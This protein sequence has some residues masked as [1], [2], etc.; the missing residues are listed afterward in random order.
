MHS[1]YSTEPTV[2]SSPV[3]S[4]PAA[5]WSALRRAPLRFAAVAFVA[6]CAA[7]V[8]SSCSSTSDPSSGG[9]TTAINLVAYSTPASAYAKLISAFEQTS[10]GKNISVTSSFGASGTQAKDV[11]NG[12][13]A[14]VVNFSLEPDMA[15]LVKAGLVSA[16]WDTVGPAHGMV[17]NSV[18]V[19]VVRKGNPDHIQNW[20]DLIRSG[21]K[22][23]TPNPFSSGSAR[24]N[25]MA[26]YGAAL[27]SGDSLPP[28]RVT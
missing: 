13:P 16:D 5:R 10:A 28:P 9:G 18:V 22:V 1:N 14:D 21:V 11:V 3:H 26:A 27:A 6:A 4:S 19:F 7:L 20:S 8:L 23:I 24:W 15:K 2:N 25:I 12:Q 17:T